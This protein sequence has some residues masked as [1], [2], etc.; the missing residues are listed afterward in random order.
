MCALLFT[1]WILLTHE[2]RVAKRCLLIGLCRCVFMAAHDRRGGGECQ[3]VV[4]RVVVSSAE[5]T[6]MTCI[7]IGL[8]RGLTMEPEKCTAGPCMAV[9]SAWDL[10]ERGEEMANPHINPRTASRGT[11]VALGR[12]E[13]A[14]TDT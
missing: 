14:V 12:K 13:G 2:Q 10:W 3:K 8:S 6:E 11:A 9:M 1:R 5:M 4:V 7:E